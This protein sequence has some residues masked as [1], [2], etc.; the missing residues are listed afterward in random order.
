LGLPLQTKTFPAM[1]IESGPLSLI[2]AMAP[3][4]D[5]VAGAQMVNSRIIS[6]KVNEMMKNDYYK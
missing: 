3:D 1:A 6:G 2:I 4:P 5:A